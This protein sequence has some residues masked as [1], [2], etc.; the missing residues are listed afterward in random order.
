MAGPHVAG[1]VALM[2]SANPKIAGKVDTIERIIELT[3]R[4]MT[5]TQNCGTIAGTQVPN[6]TYGYGRIDALAA[7]KRALLYNPTKTKLIDS[8]TVVKFYPNP[9]TAE[10]TL[11]TEGIS[12]ET[13]VEIFNTHGQRVF[14]VK[15]TFY[16]K[17]SLLIPLTEAIN[18][19]YFYKIKNGQ[20]VLTG[21]IL[22]AN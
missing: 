21:K 1:V 22:K 15:N 2:I 7:V 10:I 13:F 20:T 8:Q 6:N 17:N 16:E 3:A 9:F 12:G 5:T 4:P 14:T 18:G 19:F 11:Y